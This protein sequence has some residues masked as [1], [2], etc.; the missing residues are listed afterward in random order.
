[1]TFI[2][3]LENIG[4]DIAAGIAL[5]SKIPGIS[6]V[7]MAGPIIIEVGTVI[8][9][10][11]SKGVVVSSDQFGQILQTLAA[12]QTVRQSATGVPTIT[13]TTTHSSN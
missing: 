9:A 5:A 6:A 7:P 3:I 8:S 12:A 4:K 10:L 2:T 13:T 11:E 1:M